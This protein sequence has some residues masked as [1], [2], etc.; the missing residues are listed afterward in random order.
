VVILIFSAAFS[1]SRKRRWLFLSTV[2][3][4]PLVC[5][6]LPAASFN[7]LFRRMVDEKHPGWLD[8]SG[9]GSD[10]WIFVL[11]ALV[12]AAINLA[13]AY[14]ILSSGRQSGTGH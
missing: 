1:G 8:D 9:M 2:L 4:V 10:G 12:L 7:I 5:F 3:S 6:L 13:M 11:I 14:L